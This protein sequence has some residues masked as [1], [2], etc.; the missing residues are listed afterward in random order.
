MSRERPRDAYKH[1]IIGS[2]AAGLK[3]RHQHITQREQVQS[4]WVP[5]LG[6]FGE[7]ASGVLEKNEYV[8]IR[9]ISRT[10][11]RFRSH[12]SM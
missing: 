1:L 9:G 3:T 10:S 5:G 4:D 7:E 11:G 2:L 6:E 12:S 8:Q